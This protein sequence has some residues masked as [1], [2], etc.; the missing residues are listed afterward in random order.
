MTRAR[1][2]TVATLYLAAAFAATARGQSTGEPETV[3]VRNG[4]ITL[5]ALLWRP[6]GRGP[7]PA[8]LLNHGSGRTREELEQLGRLPVSGDT[9]S[10]AFAKSGSIV[11]VESAGIKAMHSEILRRTGSAGRMTATGCA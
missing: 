7:F 3:V 9:T 2:P 1:G 11:A 5:R 6:Q 4:P 8:I 10:T